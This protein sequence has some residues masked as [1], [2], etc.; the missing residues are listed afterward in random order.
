MKFILRAG[1]QGGGAMLA[2]PEPL[3]VKK[4]Y[5]LEKK[6]LPPLLVAPGGPLQF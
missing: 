3:S 6:L 1:L 4:A 5:I 2:G